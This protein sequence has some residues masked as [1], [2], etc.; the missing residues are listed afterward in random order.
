MNSTTTLIPEANCTLQGNPDISG[1]GVRISFYLQN[2]F[3]VFLVNR[4]YEDA[5]NALWTFIMTN[6]G[7]TLAAIVQA[8]DHQLSFFQ[9]IQVS[10][11]VWLAN[12]GTFF[13]LASYSRSRR[14]HGLPE[15]SFRR[16]FE[17]LTWPKSIPKY[18]GM[19]QMFFSMALTLYI[20]VTAKT[21]GNHTQAAC[22]QDVNYVVFF[23]ALPALRSGRIVAL[24]ITSLLTA[25]YL[26]VS[27]HELY[28]HYRSYKR[29]RVKKSHLQS[30]S[31]TSLPTSPPQADIEMNSAHQ[32]RV[33]RPVN[34]TR[35]LNH[36]RLRGDPMLVG[37]GIC[38]VF[39]F[40]Y[41]VLCS[42]LL[43]RYNTMDDSDAEWGFGQILALIVTIPSLIAVVQAFQKHGF[44]NL[45]H[46][47]SKPRRHSF[48]DFRPE[49]NSPRRD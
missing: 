43:L 30:T 36:M 3:L 18:A 27:F 7:L 25:I 35:T 9:A 15:L 24:A 21:F 33:A 2:I 45:H 41:F 42:E 32:E 26:L 20:W 16:G 48:S 46:L 38:Q 14:N 23:V 22:E 34:R 37:I 10:N 29:A 8:S 19:V 39:V 12:F 5:P 11:L 47:K 44:R 17:D 40:V 1:I 31:D 49:L 6:V 13:A 28:N 4:S